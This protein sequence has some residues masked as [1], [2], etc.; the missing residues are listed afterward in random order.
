MSSNTG[1]ADKPSGP[2]TLNIEFICDTAIDSMNKE[3]SLSNNPQQSEELYAGEEQGVD[4]DDE[5]EEEET[6]MVTALR[7]ARAKAIAKAAKQLAIEDG[8]YVP[9]KRTK[10]A[11]KISPVA[12][13]D[14][15]G[16]PG[17]SSRPFSYWRPIGAPTSTSR[18]EDDLERLRKDLLAQSI[19]ND[20][21]EQLN[22]SNYCVY[23]IF[24]DFSNH[25]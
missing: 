19:I 10:S 6:D 20:G 8:T 22:M 14:T 13:L 17:G 11:V 7:N 2:S 12:N 5:E 3:E 4:E 24:F 1:S 9:K 18:S 21:A 16:S 23:N 15:E 25:P